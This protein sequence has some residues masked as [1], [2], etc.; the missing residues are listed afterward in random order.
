MAKRDPYLIGVGNN[1]I[2][3]IQIPAASYGDTLLGYLG[4]TPL[5]TTGEIPAGKIQVGQGR[6]A[7]LQNGCFGIIL[8]YQVTTL[9]Q[10]RARVL[11]SPEKADTIFRDANNTT[12]K[13]KRIVKVE[14][15]RRRILVF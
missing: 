13:G 2:V 3:L 14:I 10:Q 5:P 4:M 8:V 9:K 1:K 11:V 12:Y 7:A 6:E 15:P